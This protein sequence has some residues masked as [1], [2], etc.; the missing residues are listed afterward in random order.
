VK[1]ATRGEFGRK[2]TTNLEGMTSRGRRG[3]KQREVKAS[4]NSEVLPVGTPSGWGEQQEGHK[5]QGVAT[6]GP[7]I[8][9][10]GKGAGNRLTAAT[11]GEGGNGPQ[12][13]LCWANSWKYSVKLR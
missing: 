9:G 3:K 4:M 5:S 6:R 2:N 8:G 11:L 13:F 1:T 12:Q 10:T 7:S